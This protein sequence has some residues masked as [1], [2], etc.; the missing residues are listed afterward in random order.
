M[1]REILVNASKTNEK[2][3]AHVTYMRTRDHLRHTSTH[4]NTNM[5]YQRTHVRRSILLN[6]INYPPHQFTHGDRMFQHKHTT[7]IRSP[8]STATSK[9]AYGKDYLTFVSKM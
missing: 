2:V 1:S 8:H 4:R 9:M 6:H 5:E 3:H 7:H